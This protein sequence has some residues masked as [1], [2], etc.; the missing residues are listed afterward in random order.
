MKKVKA[1]L[2]ISWAVL[3]LLLIIILF[4]GLNSFSARAGRLPFMKI[5]PNYTGGAPQHEYVMDNCT[6]IVRKPVFDGLIGERRVGFVQLDWHGKLPEVLN[7]TVD[8][9]S[10]GKKDFMV[11]ID[12]SNNT[13][14]LKPL[15]ARVTGPGISTPVSY[16]WCLRVE[17]KK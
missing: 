15:S 10:D 7:D 13:T 5:N 4:P 11:K 9:D 16:G 1:I 14:E 6:L 2:G 12:R 17:L 3:C 8:F